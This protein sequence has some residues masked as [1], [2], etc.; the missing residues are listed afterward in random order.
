MKINLKEKTLIEKEYSINI[1][2]INICRTETYKNDELISFKEFIDKKN[3]I[4]FKNKNRFL[5][6]WKKFGDFELNF[7]KY[8]IKEPFTYL[9]DKNNFKNLILIETNGHEIYKDAITGKILPKA[10]FFNYIN[11]NIDNEYYDLKKLLNH[12]KTFDNIKFYNNTYN[13]ELEK[14]E[15]IDIPYYNAENGKDKYINFIIDPTKNWNDV[16]KYYEQYWND[17][18]KYYEQYWND[19]EKYY[20]Q[21]WNDVEKY[22]EQYLNNEIKSHWDF[23]DKLKDYFGI[24]NFKKE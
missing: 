2:N 18:E 19:V 10:I 3:I 11:G 17:V 8:Y 22:Y 20:E 5:N 23:Y 13:K 1:N 24:N 15:I 16:E 6:H 12:L 14:Q 9:K 21:Y 7:N 4:L